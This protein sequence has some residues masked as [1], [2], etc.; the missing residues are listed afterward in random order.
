MGAMESET[1][2]IFSQLEDAKEIRSGNFTFCEG[3][4]NGY[5][6]VA[7]RTSIGMANAGAVTALVIERYKPSCIIMQGT[8]GGHNP[9]YHQYDIVLGENIINIGTYVSAHKDAGQGSCTFDWDFPGTLSEDLGGAGVLHSDENLMTL[10]ESV[11]YEKARIYRGGIGC[12]DAWN[13]EIDLINF[14]HKSKGT[15]C[16]EMEGYAVAQIC[17]AYNVPYLILRVISNS[18]L[19][20][21]E[22][23]DPD[24]ASECQKYSLG[25]IKKLIEK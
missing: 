25:I 13:R 12:A 3:K 7:V 9:D 21:S 24:T 8:A 15:D 4:L 14:F 5:P 22:E 20:P 6:V 11:P 17:E 10:A 23:F 16:E 1:S 19:H 2:Y 18:E